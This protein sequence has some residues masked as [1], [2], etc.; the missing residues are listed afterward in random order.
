MV[1]RLT[2]TS[3]Q[4]FMIEIVFLSTWLLPS[5]TT[6]R[7]IPA[8]A[9]GSKELPENVKARVGTPIATGRMLNTRCEYAFCPCCVSSCSMPD[10]RVVHFRTSLD[11]RGGKCQNTGAP[12]NA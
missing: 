1:R 9:T 7:T 6:Y 10:R 4:A 11:A 3:S 12:L 8:V 2:P 5:E